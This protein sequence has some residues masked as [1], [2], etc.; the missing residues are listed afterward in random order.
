M[1]EPRSS[2]TGRATAVFAKR[3]QPG[4]VKT[5]LCPPLSPEQAAG[6][7]ADMLADVMAQLSSA[8]ELA[9]SLHFAPAEE[10]AWFEERYRPPGGLHAQR[11][12]GLGERLAGYF[13]HELAPGGARTAVVVGSDVPLI[14][15]AR[16]ES[17]HLELEGGADLV[18]GP[19]RGGGYYLVG[20]R[21]PAPEL[22]IEVPMST[23]GMCAATAEL[24]RGRGLRV[25]L[26]EPGYDVDLEEDLL[27]LRRD[28][29]QPEALR[30]RG[31]CFPEETAR[32]L[33]E[34]A[35]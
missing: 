22:F 11:G 3:P 19:D 7:A 18:L 8:P 34:L 30:A 25:A 33:A 23:R 13:E 28:L 27:A 5:R 2:R 20:L 32:F 31:L 9:L 6:L 1:D 17:A 15:P 16:V 26:L 12:E 35:L 21:R 24:A 29:E 14:S 10:R 4:R